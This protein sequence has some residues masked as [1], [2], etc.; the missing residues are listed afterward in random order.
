MIK[1]YKRIS[2]KW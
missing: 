1:D 2:W